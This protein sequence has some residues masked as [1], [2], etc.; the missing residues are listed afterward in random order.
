MK[1]FYSKN[2]GERLIIIGTA[3][4]ASGFILPLF[5]LL[6]LYSSANKCL[7]NHCRSIGNWGYGTKLTVLIPIGLIILLIGSFLDIKNSRRPKA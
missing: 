1:W 4:I 5:S 7:D 2:I 3:L 6:R